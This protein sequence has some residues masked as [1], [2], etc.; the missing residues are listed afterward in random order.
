MVDF[1]GRPRSL[2]VGA[3][4]AIA[5]ILSPIGAQSS[6]TMPWVVQNDPDVMLKAGEQGRGFAVSVD[7]AATFRGTS[8]FGD[9]RAQEPNYQRLAIFI[10]N[11]KRHALALFMRDGAERMA[12]VDLE[13]GVILND[14]PRPFWRYGPTDDVIWEPQGRYAAVRLPMAE[15]STG[16]GVFELSTGQYAVIPDRTFDANARDSWLADSLRTRP[17]GS[18]AIEVALQKFDAHGTPMHSNGTPAETRIIDFAAAFDASAADSEGSHD[19]KSASPIARAPW[20][21][22]TNAGGETAIRKIVEG[23]VGGPVEVIL[24]YANAFPFPATPLT[25]LAVD[26]FNILPEADTAT[27]SGSQMGFG[28]LILRESSGLNRYYFQDQP[29]EG[30]ALAT[31][32]T[33][34]ELRILSIKERTGASCEW[35]VTYRLWLA[36]R[37]PFG[38]ALEQVSGNDGLTFAACFRTTRDW[39]R[40]G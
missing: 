23:F 26:L 29:S 16:L 37:T 33:V 27:K 13:G 18:V 36:N 22:Q 17:D 34:D 6:S 1:D 5:L 12:L 40:G 24:Q 38:I 7:G 21:F 31:L 30:L 28:S 8:L 4:F 39:S 10:V 2:L 3:F 25:Q 15:Y 14:A 9:Y 35:S 19:E 20:S 11:A 32:G